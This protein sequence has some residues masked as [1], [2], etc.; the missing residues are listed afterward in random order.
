[1]SSCNNT[2][3]YTINISEQEELKVWNK[4]CSF[5]TPSVNKSVGKQEKKQL[6]GSLQWG[7]SNTCKD[8]YEQQSIVMSFIHSNMIL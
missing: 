8:N 2:D 1:M 5:S 6:V 3:R 4:T 7:D